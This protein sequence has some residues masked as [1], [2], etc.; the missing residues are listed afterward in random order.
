MVAILATVNEADNVQLVRAEGGVL[1]VFPMNVTAVGVVS[2]GATAPITS[3]GGATPVIGIAPATDLAAGSLSAADK[4]KLDGLSPTPVD[5]V[6]VSAPITNTGTAQ[7]PVLGFAGSD[8]NASGQV[9]AISGPSPI[10][11]TPALFSWLQTTLAPGLTQARAANA[12]APQNLTLT[13]QAPGAAATNATNGTPGSVVVQ[14]SAPV[15]SGAD[16]F[17]EVQFPGGPPAFMGPVPS[18]ETLGNCLYFTGT[19]QAFGTGAT[20]SSAGNNTTINAP[21][22][23]GTSQLNLQ[24]LGATGGGCFSDQGSGRGFNLTGFNTTFGGG[25]EVAKLQNATTEPTSNAV[26]SVFWAFTDGAFK[27]RSS[28]GYTTN[29]AA[30]GDAATG[31]QQ[32]LTDAYASNARTVSSATP[33][34]LSTAYTTKANTV[35]WMT[36]RLVSKAAT[37]GTGIAAGDGVMATYVLGYKNVAGTVTLATAGITL[38]GA[39]QTTAAALTSVLTA[40]ASTNTVVLSVTNT[41]LCTVDSQVTATIDVC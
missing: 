35:G 25:V 13:P 11:V 40:A 5:S 6:T 28:N 34:A 38:V 19:P 39:A 31:S 17:F 22:S 18:L 4:T 8:I 10:N 2:V 14:L 26:G 36:I 37:A 33:T 12:S 1:P 7:D 23:G 27:I 15:N 20:L 16:P 32:R 30:L 21:T 41:N 24:I 29:V 3:T 9:A